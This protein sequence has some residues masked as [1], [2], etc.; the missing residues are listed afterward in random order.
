MWKRKTVSDGI[1]IA[2]F[3]SKNRTVSDQHL[4]QIFAD[5]GRRYG[6]DDV[7]AEF[8]P[9]TDFKVR[10]QRTSEWIRFQIS[11]YLD[12]APDNI[13]VG[14]ADVLYAKI[15]GEDKE[16][17]EAFIRYV[18]DESVAGPNQ[19]DFLSRSRNLGGSS[20]GDYHDLNDCVNR[21]RDEGLIPDDLQCE[22]RWDS[23]PG[24][25]AAG[26]SVL[27]R[28]VWVS[29][30]LDQK[31]VP[32]NVLDYCV[33]SMLCHLMVGFTGRQD[34]AEHRRLVSRYP[35]QADAEEW[36]YRQDLYL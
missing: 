7:G 11:D 22:L 25:K 27:Q 29:R 6:Y 8:S 3:N 2:T 15:R 28:V 5:V 4:T 34:E 17:D 30:A 14:L 1:T 21:L 23:S 32:E 26:C 9:L 12:R 33:Y 10:W 18:T 16:Y 31:G 24:G 13:L 20:V 35:M 19:K 36:L